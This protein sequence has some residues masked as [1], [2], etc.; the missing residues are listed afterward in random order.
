MPGVDP[1]KFLNLEGRAVPER[2]GVILKWDY[3]FLLIFS[4]IILD[5]CNLNFG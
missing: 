5:L 3:P 4:I 1:D 2:E